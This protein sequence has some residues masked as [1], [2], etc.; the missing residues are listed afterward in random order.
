M[1]SLVLSAAEPSGDR[2]AA[3]AIR[4]L[5]DSG[6]RPRYAGIAGSLM[7]QAAA[8]AGAVM[9]VAGN[10]DDLGAAGLVE[11]LPALPRLWRARQTLDRLLRERQGPALLVDAPDLHIPAAKR[12]RR[13]AGRPIGI[14][15]APQYWAWRPDRATTLC[16]AV[17]FVLC[18]FRFE[19]EH[20]R[21]LGVMAHW[22]GHP[23]L[24]SV[25]PAGQGAPP[26]RLVVAL[27]PGSRAA[28]VGALLRPCVRGIRAALAGQGFEILVPWRLRQPPPRMDGVTFTAEAGSDALARAHLAVVA[29]GT[30]TLEA[31]LAGLP[32]VVVARV[33]PISA[34]IARRALTVRWVGL[35]NLLL[36]RD[37]VPEV[38]QDLS[39]VALAT[40]IRASAADAMQGA[41][42]ARA[43]AEE[44]R[45]RLGPPGFGERVA[46]AL[47]PL[48]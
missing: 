42:G 8:G 41:S 30:A 18:L 36:G 43:L 34:A 5:A 14:L 31:T 9:D 15:V 21:R 44:L 17:D 29:A 27:L 10:A 26:E 38:I 47:E 40:A 23:A 33:H 4:G 35:P 22:V 28:E 1:N 3:A 48:L 7:R 11:I 19:A 6:H 2:L 46:L 12:A 25:A 20:L 45:E 24:D 37:A 32:T 16:Q 13:M 39:P